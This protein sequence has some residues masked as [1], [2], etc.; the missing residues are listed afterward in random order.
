M[1]FLGTKEQSD[2][3]KRVTA[4]EHQT[5]HEDSKDFHR[6]GKLTRPIAQQRFFSFINEHDKELANVY[7][8]SYEKWL[9]EYQ[10]FIKEVKA[11]PDGGLLLDSFKQKYSYLGRIPPDGSPS[12]D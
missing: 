12:T 9:K 1:G 8:D 2:Y 4:R 5:H 10:A 7:K 3:S 6:V 11:L